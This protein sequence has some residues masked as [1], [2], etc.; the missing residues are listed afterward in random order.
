M[1]ISGCSAI[2][3]G[4]TGGMGEATVRRLYA[5]GAQMVGGRAELKQPGGP[6]E[7]LPGYGLPVR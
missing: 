2:V 4:G 1:Q 5:A 7:G 6:L 3:T